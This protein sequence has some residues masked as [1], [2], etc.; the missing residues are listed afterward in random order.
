MSKLWL[1]SSFVSKNRMTFYFLRIL[2]WCSLKACLSNG[3][4]H[5]RKLSLK[6]CMPCKC[7]TCKFSNVMNVSKFYN[8]KKTQHKLFCF[9]RMHKPKPTW[10]E[11]SATFVCL[12]SLW[13]AWAADEDE[14]K[15]E[16]NTFT[17]NL[18]VL[19]VN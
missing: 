12:W 15:L 11:S 7:A 18:S 4:N 5:T 2:T 8:I 17:A 14:R 10:K 9:L 6:P 13:N 3:L 1:R 19:I 16:A